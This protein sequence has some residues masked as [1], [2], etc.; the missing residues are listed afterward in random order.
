M[1]LIIGL[2][3][4]LLV[5]TVSC[6]SREASSEPVSVVRMQWG[7]SIDGNCKFAGEDLSRYPV[8][9]RTNRENCL[10]AVTIGPM[11]INELEH[12]KRDVSQFWE[13]SFPYQQAL[14]GQR[15]DGKCSFGSPALQAYLEFSEVASIIE[16][17]CVMIVDVGP[18]TKRQIEEVQRHGMTESSTAAP[19]PATPVAGQ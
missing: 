10:Q 5:L 6:G 3:V 12:M 13:E 17:N 4:A 11:S 1:R 9:Y 8:S 7:E 16:E 2:L 19:A 14:F 18:A 15:V